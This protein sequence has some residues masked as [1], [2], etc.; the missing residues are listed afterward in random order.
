MRRMEQL[1]P[2]QLKVYKFVE[3]FT[4]EKEYVPS[5]REIQAGLGLASFSSISVVMD[6]LE[7]KGYIARTGKGGSRNY[8]LKKNDVLVDA[9][10]KKLDKLAPRDRA[11][12]QKAIDVLK[13]K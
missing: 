8:Q 13:D 7:A 6:K 3:N 4:K 1:T 9:L 5:L 11:A 10:E 2:T 12:V